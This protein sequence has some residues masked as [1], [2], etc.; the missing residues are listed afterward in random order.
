[1]IDYSKSTSFCYHRQFQTFKLEQSIEVY[2]FVKSY[3]F[4]VHIVVAIGMK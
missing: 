4:E 2:C 1:M 3:K